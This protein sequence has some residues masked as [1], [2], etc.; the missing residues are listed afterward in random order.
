MVNIVGH[1]S[2][3]PDV[4]GYANVIPSLDWATELA[5]ERWR[6]PLSYITGW[7]L[8]LAWQADLAS[9]AYLVG[10]L[11]Q[12]LIALNHPEYDEQGWQV[13]VFADTLVYPS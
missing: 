9:V 6:R 8:F 7:L 11:I 2:C 1:H 12:G 5:P 3:R 13:R 10:T 4:R